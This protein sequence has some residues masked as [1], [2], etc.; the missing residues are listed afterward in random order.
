MVKSS[1]FQFVCLNDVFLSL[2]LLHSVIKAAYKCT[3]DWV[4][5]SRGAQIHFYAL[6]ILDAPECE[7]CMKLGQQ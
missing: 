2:D 3:L 7:V 6:Q 1:G 4:I 5:P